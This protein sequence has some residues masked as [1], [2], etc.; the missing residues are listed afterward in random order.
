MV[1]DFTP[2]PVVFS[3]ISYDSEN[4]L[5]SYNEVR[6]V[7]ISGPIT[8]RVTYS[9]TNL[10]YRS[11][12]VSLLDNEPAGSFNESPD[13]VGMIPI[14]NNGTFQVANNNYL[15]FGNSGDL[16][17][18]TATVINVSDSNAELGSFYYSYE[19]G[20]MGPS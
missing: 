6:I 16:S 14:A 5:F 10:Y 11:S 18:F 4:Y 15:S 13:L 20:M 1:D 17:N 19:S 3:A 7:G 9:G 8:L 2:D 12:P